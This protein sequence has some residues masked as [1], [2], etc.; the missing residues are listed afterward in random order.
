MKSMV[1][2]VPLNVNPVHTLGRDYQRPV[3]TETEW[4]KGRSESPSP[5]SPLG[6]HTSRGEWWVKSLTLF[7]W[8]LSSSFICWYQEYT[9]EFLWLKCIWGDSTVFKD[10]K[11]D[12]WSIITEVTSVW[13]ST[14]NMYCIQHRTTLFFTNT[15]Y[16]LDNA[17]WMFHCNHKKT[18][19]TLMKIPTSKNS[20][21]HKLGKLYFH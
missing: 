2:K 1:W 20:L 12:Y 11:G 7:K 13:T 8:L 4:A 10:I 17:W 14:L 3:G 6:A 5:L 19:C 9:V 21:Y 18:T 16:V 15:F